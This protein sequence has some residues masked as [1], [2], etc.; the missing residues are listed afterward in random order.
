MATP[1]AEWV[2]RWN[3]Q[4]IQADLSALFEQIDFQA[5]ILRLQQLPAQLNFME[6][7][8]LYKSS[9]LSPGPNKLTPVE[10]IYKNWTDLPGSSL[11]ISKAKGFLL[12]DPAMHMK[13]LLQSLQIDVPAEFATTPDHLLLELEFAA[14]LLQ[15]NN[16]QF[17]Q[18]FL[19]DHLD[20]T[21]LLVADARDKGWQGFYLQWLE[22]IDAFVGWERM[23]RA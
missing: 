23:A 9:F 16:P 21:G 1:C 10:S 2:N 8:G 5:G 15:M 17:K 22:L 12:G 4:E 18:E 3:Q 6:L 19:N 20:W 14:L 13:F 7:T 11:T